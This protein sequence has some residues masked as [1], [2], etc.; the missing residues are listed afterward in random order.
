MGTE[1][2]KDGGKKAQGFC[3]KHIILL[4]IVCF[5]SLIAISLGILFYCLYL[6][7]GEPSGSSTTFDKIIQDVNA[8]NFTSRN[9]FVVAEKN[10]PNLS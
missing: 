10:G 5:F 8:Y 3:C 1:S 6:S 2:T 9:D 7:E 4:S